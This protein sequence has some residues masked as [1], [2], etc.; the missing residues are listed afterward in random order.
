MDLSKMIADVLRPWGYKAK[1]INRRGKQELLVK[2]NGGAEYVES[3]RYDGG[4][5]RV[6]SWAA[7]PKEGRRLAPFYDKLG[8][9]WPNTKKMLPE[10]FTP[11]SSGEHHLIGSSEFLGTKSLQR[12][13]KPDALWHVVLLEKRS[14]RPADIKKALHDFCRLRAPRGSIA[15]KWLEEGPAKGYVDVLPIMWF[16]REGRIDRAVH[17]VRGPRDAAYM[18]TCRVTVKRRVADLDYA[19]FAR[20]NGRR[21]MEVGTMRIVFKNSDRDTVISVKWRELTGSFRKAPV[22]CSIGRRRLRP[23][24]TDPGKVTREI[25]RRPDQRRF[26]NE[27]LQFYG[28]RCCLSGCP[29]DEALEAAHIARYA[30]KYDNRPSN[31][32]LLRSDLHALFDADLL[33]FEPKSLT[34]HFAESVRGY[35]QGSLLKTLRSPDD[36]EARPSQEALTGRWKRFQE[37][38]SGRSVR[39]GRR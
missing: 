32:L 39:E 9:D 7:P 36:R 13:L 17:V 28:G 27:L 4:K 34:A 21:D 3:F 38:T 11:S 16:A 5:R 15:I 26:R 35:Y 14:L 31:G 37:R 29:V 25:T 33:A 18:A 8:F 23:P 24:A 30:D 19:A 22:S 20:E 1:P 6:L 2:V 10:P 12:M